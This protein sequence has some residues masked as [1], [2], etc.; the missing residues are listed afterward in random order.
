MVGLPSVGFPPLSS[1]SS[2]SFSSSCGILARGGSEVVVVAHPVG[3]GCASEN[4]VLGAQSGPS[5]NNG[6]L[7]RDTVGVN[8]ELTIDAWPLGRDAGLKRLRVSSNAEKQTKFTK[9]E[10]KF[11]IRRRLS[12]QVDRPSRRRYFSSLRTRSNTR[13]TSSLAAWHQWS[14]SPILTKDFTI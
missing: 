5:R 1:L 4:F 11:E 12:S 13:S 8:V 14:K 2:P 6:L 3:G 9:C 7:S 10:F